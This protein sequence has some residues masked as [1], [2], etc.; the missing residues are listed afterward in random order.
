[1]KY[2]SYRPSACNITI[3]VEQHPKIQE[4]NG[5]RCVL[6]EEQAGIKIDLMKALLLGAILTDVVCR[7]IGCQTG[8]RPHQHGLATY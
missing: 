3:A 5:I 4:F 2:S 7:S 8:D 6:W 1:M